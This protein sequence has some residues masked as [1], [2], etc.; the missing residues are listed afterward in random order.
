MSRPIKYLDGYDRQIIHARPQIRKAARCYWC[1]EV[2]PKGSPYI[3]LRYV[4]EDQTD[5]VNAPM[6]QAC[7]RAW[8]SKEAHG[9][10]EPCP[11]VACSCWVPMR[12]PRGTYTLGGPQFEDTPTTSL[13]PYRGQTVPRPAV[14]FGAREAPNGRIVL[15]PA[16]EKLVDAYN[17]DYS[18]YN[19]TR[20]EEQTVKDHVRKVMDASEGVAEQELG[21]PDL[22]LMAA[23]AAKRADAV[24]TITH[25]MQDPQ[26]LSEA[27]YSGYMALHR[28]FT[29][30]IPG[31]WQRAGLSPT[32]SSDMA[33]CVLDQIRRDNPGWFGNPFCTDSDDLL[34]AAAEAIK[35]DQVRRAASR[36]QAASAN[37]AVEAANK[38]PRPP[39]LPGQTP[40]EDVLINVPNW[41]DLRLTMP[42]RTLPL[43]QVTRLVITKPIEDAR[44]YVNHLTQ[45]RMVV[46]DF[47][48]LELVDARGESQDLSL[49]FRGL[50]NYV[51]ETETHVV[52]TPARPFYDNPPFG[53]GL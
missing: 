31:A 23:Q 3:N 14:L 51:F 26:R 47:G 41:M 22:A 52:V 8:K 44:T 50:G 35:S 34:Y 4:P 13:H 43:S 20:E 30:V 38:F 24:A 53:R 16:T 21:N 12:M 17:P 9:G 10:R 32:H 29:E 18:K 25:L 48:I 27:R 39:L 40:C 2:I 6:H 36:L 46:E 45:S 28:I 37:A 33:S 7:Y 1:G 42:T 15:L 49:L 11:R 5:A 19:L